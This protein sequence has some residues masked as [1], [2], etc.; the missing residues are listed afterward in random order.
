MLT[1]ELERSQ[2][3][4]FLGPGPVTEHVTHARGFAAGLDEPPARFLD[5]GSGGGV[6]GLVLALAWPS[7]SAVLLD[8]GERRADFLRE[9]VGRLG[10]GERVEVV[11]G[12]A[13]E[14]GRAPEL[15]GAFDLV[16][17]RAFGPPAATAECGAPFLRVG[18]KLVV[19]E[20]P[21][22][23]DRWPADGL[24]QLGLAR[25]LSWRAPHAYQSLVQI[26]ACPDR[27]PRRVGRPAKRPLF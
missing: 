12:R 13:E 9:A 4:G 5:L 1:A 14:L 6:P 23:G 25:G 19:S 26:E 10:L 24:A 15:R 7:A 2:R 8:A 3:S 18:G 27:Y 21:E 17:A 20:P 22:P 11:R 16:V